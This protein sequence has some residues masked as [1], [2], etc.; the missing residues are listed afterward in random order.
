V[1]RAVADTSSNTLRTGTAS[2]LPHSDLTLRQRPTRP[3][4]YSTVQQLGQINRSFPLQRSVQNLGHFG[5]GIV[6][7][8][9]T[10]TSCRKAAPC[11]LRAS[12]PGSATTDQEAEARTGSDMSQ[13]RVPCIGSS[14]TAAR[15]S[16]QN[17]L[18]T[19]SNDAS[20]LKKAY[21]RLRLPFLPHLLQPLSLFIS[22][23][24]VS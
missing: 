16:G 15:T 22:L 14:V 7:S 9:S 4:P 8:E 5:T 13:T 1:T 21:S 3:F 11:S 20:C 6:H 19:H 12:G 24:S 10:Q 18:A 2:H 23:S 17:A